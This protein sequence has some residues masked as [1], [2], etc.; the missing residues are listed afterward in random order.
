MRDCLGGNP[1]QLVI[2]FPL[3]NDNYDK[4]IDCL[5]T[6]YSR[7]DECHEQIINKVIFQNWKDVSVVKLMEKVT[8]WEINIAVLK[9]RFNLDLLDPSIIKLTA[10]VFKKIWESYYLDMLKAWDLKC[11][12]IK[13]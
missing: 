11:K 5:T 10:D 13:H 7:D 8:E 9:S 4:A 12:K 6:V 3:I 1:F 2:N